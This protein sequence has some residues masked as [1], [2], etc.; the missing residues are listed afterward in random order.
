MTYRLEAVANRSISLKVKAVKFYNKFEKSK[1]DER[2][3]PSIINTSE[4]NSYTKII[5]C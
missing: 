2:K 4:S 1:K 5:K 3:I